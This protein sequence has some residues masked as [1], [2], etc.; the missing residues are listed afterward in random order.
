MTLRKN[1]LILKII[2]VLLFLLLFNT[3]GNSQIFKHLNFPEERP[4]FPISVGLG[5]G[6]NYG[7]LGIKTI[8]GKNNSGLLISV[9]SPDGLP[10]GQIGLQIAK[11]NGFFVNAGYGAYGVIFENDNRNVLLGAIIMVGA[12]HDLI[13]TRRLFL[14]TGLG[15]AFGGSYFSFFENKNIPVSSFTFHVGLG[16]RLGNLDE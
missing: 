11:T 15:I 7:L 13:R 3:S 1:P 4:N 5:L 10:T 2:G 16:Y 8:I 14:D 6:P 9:G 12:M